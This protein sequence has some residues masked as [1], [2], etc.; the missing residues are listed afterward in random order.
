VINQPCHSWII[1][2]S[3]ETLCF[4]KS[5]PTA[6]C[7]SLGDISP[8]EFLFQMADVSSTSHDGTGHTHTN[9]LHWEG[10]PR[11]L[12]ESL[13]LFYYTEPPQYDCF[14]YTAEGVT[15]CTVKITI[16]Q[17]PFRAHWQPIEIETFGYRLAD[18]VEAAA[19]E[20]ITAF[21]EQHPNEVAEYPIGLFPAA[22]YHDPE[23][24]FRVEHCAHLLG[25][26]A[27]DTVRMMVRFMNAQLR[28][29]EL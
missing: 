12:W 17:H 21:C 20:A 15:R 1:Y 10:F 2:D 24:S 11:L 29:Q 7:P 28:H 19:L 27:G 25:D 13:Q 5:Y 9:G 23:W 26:S 16:P 22:N 4:N 18:T 8:F 6:F 14:T 3:F